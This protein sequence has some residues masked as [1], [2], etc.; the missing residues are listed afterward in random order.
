MGQCDSLRVMTTI[1]NF[2]QNFSLEWCSCNKGS[3]K[4]HLGFCNLKD[5]GLG[6]RRLADLKYAVS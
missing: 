4:S 2:S 1:G 6:L 3:C 5:G